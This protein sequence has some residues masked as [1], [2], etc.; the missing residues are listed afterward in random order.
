MPN[1]IINIPKKKTVFLFRY[2]IRNN[3]AGW[4]AWGLENRKS[5]VGVDRKA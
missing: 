1:I 5:I 4:N 2:F 3:M